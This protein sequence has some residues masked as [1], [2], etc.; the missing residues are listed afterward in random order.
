MPQFYQPGETF[1]GMFSVSD[2]TGSAIWV[3]ASALIYRNNVLDTSVVPTMGTPSIGQQAYSF[4]IPSGYSAGDVVTV[5]GTALLPNA[6]QLAQTVNQVRLNGLASWTPNDM[7]TIRTATAILGTTNT[8]PSTRQYQYT[9][10][11][12]KTVTVNVSSD[13]QTQ[14]ITAV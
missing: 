12:G 1:R 5:V 4:L 10:S 11:D 9:Q 8:N 3:A 7:A 6:T 2:S 14:T 13:G